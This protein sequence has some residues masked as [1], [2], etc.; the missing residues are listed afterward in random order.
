MLLG[1]EVTEEE[2]DKAIG[3]EGKVLV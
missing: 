3:K 1:E 2:L